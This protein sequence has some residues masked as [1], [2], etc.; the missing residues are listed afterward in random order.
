ME[1]TEAL[2]KAI[3]ERGLT[4]SEVA[5]RLGK[6]KGFVS[7]LLAGGRNLTLRTIADVADAIGISLRV[8]VGGADIAKARIR[9]PRT[10][11]SVQTGAA[12][13]FD[14]RQWMH[15]QSGRSNFR[16]SIRGQKGQGA[17][18]DAEQWAA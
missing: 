3:E 4:R 10:Y 16:Y 11:V 2:S 17:A 6:T 1:V 13:T 12:W 9:P 14:S 18:A 5:K 15:R 8:A 7:Q